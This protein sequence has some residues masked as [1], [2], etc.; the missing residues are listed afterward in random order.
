MYIVIFV[1]D[2]NECDS[3]PCQNGGTCT[4]GVNGYTCGC[5]DGYTGTHCETGIC[6]IK[7]KVCNSIIGF[8]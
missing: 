4:D 8:S 6:F 3:N 2:I 1:T 5:A 7:G